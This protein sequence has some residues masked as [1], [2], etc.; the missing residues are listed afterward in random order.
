[1][2]EERQRFRQKWLWL[3]MT[4]TLVGPLVVAVGAWQ[5][6][7]QGRPFG[8]HPVSNGGLLAILGGTLLVSSLVWGLLWRMELRV[9]VDQTNVTIRFAPFPTRVIPRVMIRRA[10]AETYHPIREFGGW[11][12]RIGAHRRAYSVSGDRGVGLELADGTR[13]LIGSQ[14]ADELAR[15]LRS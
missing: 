2:F 11:G 10:E 14:R 4:T 7:G 6:I 3:V 12:V 5:Q 8:N 13:L 9:R 15:A 1:M